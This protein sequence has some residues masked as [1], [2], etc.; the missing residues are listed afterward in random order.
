MAVP[1][2]AE[3]MV[4]VDSC[5]RRALACWQRSQ[6]GRRTELRAAARALPNAEQLLALPRQ[7][8][9]QASARLPRALIANAQLHHAAYSRLAGRLTP[10]TL[11]NH[12]RREREHTAML[13]RRSAHCLRVHVE[14]RRER[15]DAFAVRLDVARTAYIDARKTEIARRRERIEVFATRAQ[16]AFERLLDDRAAR[17][18]RAERLLAAVSYRGVLARGFAL[19]R[20]LA[21]RPLRQAAAVTA[22][23]RIDIEFSDGRVRALAEVSASDA[24]APP[25]GILRR[26]RRRRD[27][28]DTGQGSLFDS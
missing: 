16:R 6:D 12:I 25:Q 24:P 8:L 2:R 26:R 28:G 9:D 21:G 10:Q 15:Y 5:A 20:D 18:E 22:G 23:E 27:D 11:G 17:V 1:V 14:R 13:A 3:L 19:V 4:R 7:R